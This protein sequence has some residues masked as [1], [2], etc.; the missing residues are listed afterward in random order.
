MNR[1]SQRLLDKAAKYRQS[2]GLLGEAGD[3]DS[4]TSRLYY[5]MFFCARAALWS[6][7]QTYSKHQGV[8]SGFGQHLV[9][10]G[11]LPAELHLWLR[12]AFDLRQESDYMSE[13]TLGADAV[14]GLQIRAEAFASQI[15]AWL[16]QREP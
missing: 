1:E 5:A 3:F 6:V 10:T 2:A 16:R 4:A 9:K 11:E 8:L 7:G 14:R 15:D 12:Q 13:S